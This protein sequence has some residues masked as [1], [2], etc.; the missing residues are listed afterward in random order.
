[1]MD[2]NRVINDCLEIGILA[3]GFIL[4]MASL[5]AFIVG[6]LSHGPW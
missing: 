6:V 1:M 5:I 4:I 2:E 3:G